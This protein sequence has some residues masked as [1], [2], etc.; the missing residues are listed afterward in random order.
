[1]KAELGQSSYRVALNMC[2]VDAFAERWPCYGERNELAF[3]FSRENGDLIDLEG[4]ESGTDERGIAALSNDACLAGAI[5]LR[6]NDV[7]EMRRVY[8][9]PDSVAILLESVT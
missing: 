2:D 1:M 7:T 9:D 4:E 6:L 8:G 3:T 5:A